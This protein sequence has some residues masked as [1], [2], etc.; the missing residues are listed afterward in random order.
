MPTYETDEEDYKHYMDSLRDQ[1]KDYFDGGRTKILIDH[2]NLEFSLKKLR[3][4]FD[5]EKFRNE[6]KA[7]ANLRGIYCFVS[8]LPNDP[9]RGKFVSF[10]EYNGYR[11]IRKDAKSTYMGE[12][13]TLPI[14]EEG[15]TEGGWRSEPEPL[16]RIKGNVDVELTI[17]AL[18]HCRL[19]DHIVILSGDGDFRM[20]VEQLQKNGKEVTVMSTARTQPSVVADELRRQADNFIELDEF[21]PLFEKL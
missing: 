5:Y 15:A 2:A 11:V 8:V 3:F 4:R 13:E 1:L 20:L 7:S 9:K 21:R 10:L 6:M 17:Y 18:E 16:R 14:L 19:A 12:G